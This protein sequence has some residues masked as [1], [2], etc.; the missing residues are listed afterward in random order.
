MKKGFTLVELITVI[1]ILSILLII[2]IPKMLDLVD[3]KTVD[4]MKD[5]SI[6]LIN[7]AEVE[8]MSNNVP[9][10]TPVIEYN[11]V[12][13]AQESCGILHNLDTDSFSSC[14]ISIDIETGE[15]NHLELEGKKNSDFDGFS[16]TYNG[17]SIDNID[18]RKN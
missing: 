9:G 16:C 11:G 14:T 12:D 4:S 6:M 7:K 15:V 2:T 13:K 1:T 8:Y 17:G 5:L 3:N 18:C 10:K